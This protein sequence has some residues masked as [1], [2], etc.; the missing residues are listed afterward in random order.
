MKFKLYAIVNSLIALG[1]ILLSF[2]LED[3]Y[4]K[5]IL[6]I[7]A[8]IILLITRNILIKPNQSPK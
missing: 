8:I 6:K 3:E 5:D 7:L 1:L 4:T 2:Q